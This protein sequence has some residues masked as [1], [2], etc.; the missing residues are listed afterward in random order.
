[1]QA[2]QDHFFPDLEINPPGVVD[3]TL[4]ERGQSSDGG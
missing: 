3:I 1:M 2:L 4:P